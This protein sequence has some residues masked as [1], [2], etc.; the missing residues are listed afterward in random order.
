MSDYLI[1]VQD[2]DADER[3]PF[4]LQ[5]E[6]P[7]MVVNGFVGAMTKSRG[8]GVPPLVSGLRVDAMLDPARTHLA[9]NEVVIAGTDIRRITLLMEFTPD[10]AHRL[11]TS[12]DRPPRQITEG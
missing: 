8:P 4:L 9:V 3:Y 10:S 7:M 11:T 2:P 1:R 6:G 12:F 5:V